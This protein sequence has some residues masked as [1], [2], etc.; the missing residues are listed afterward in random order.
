MKKGNYYTARMSG[1]TVTN[2]TAGSR[3]KKEDLDKQIYWEDG[4]ITKTGDAKLIGNTMIVVKTD[5][6][7]NPNEKIS[8]NKKNQPIYIAN[9]PPNTECEDFCRKRKQNCCSY[10]KKR[11]SNEI[12][13]T[14]KY[15][16]SKY[17]SRNKCEMSNT[18]ITNPKY[19]CG[20][21]CYND[22][23]CTGYTIG[24]KNYGV[25]R[26]E[27]PKSIRFNGTNKLILTFSHKFVSDD[28]NLKLIYKNKS[29]KYI[30]NISQSFSLKTSVIDVER[31]TTT[32][33]N[34]ITPPAEPKITSA[35]TVN[36]SNDITVEFKNNIK[37]P[38]GN[39][40]DIN[41]NPINDWT[42]EYKDGEEIEKSRVM[43]CSLY[44][45]DNKPMDINTRNKYGRL[46]EPTY[47]Y[48]SRK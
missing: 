40:K 5:H 13:K 6:N 4:T 34:K 16:G 20:S 9:T 42:V 15:D 45:K 32:L 7:L 19:R 22:P 23:N 2:T 37:F 18:Y 48:Y 26:T 39:I 28:T 25:K 1:Q 41:R 10:I 8:S 3:F 11:A 21:L 29:G 27:S 12:D 47:K 17:S 43:T 30:K 33:Q 14:F 38:T 46:E 36:D 24:T 31:P 44:G 35:K